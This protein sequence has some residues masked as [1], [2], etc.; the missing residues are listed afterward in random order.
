MRF[1]SV[2]GASDQG[3]ERAAHYTFDEVFALFTA[4]VEVFRA[5]NADADFP[6]DAGFYRL[7]DGQR[8]LEV[9]IADDQE[10]D[11]AASVVDSFG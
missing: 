7:Y 10:V 3:R 9:E 8:L 11:I 1:S 5:E 2:I 4:C 6:A